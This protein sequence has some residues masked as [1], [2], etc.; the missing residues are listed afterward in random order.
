MHSLLAISAC[1]VMGQI[2][3]LNNTDDNQVWSDL[4]GTDGNE[5]ASDNFGYI[6]A[7]I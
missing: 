2:S 7:L 3:M 4:L 6:I 5:S 1:S